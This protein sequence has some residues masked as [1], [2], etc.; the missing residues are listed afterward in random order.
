MVKAIDVARY[1]LY[2][3]ACEPE[4]EPL[5]PL[6]LQKLLY[7]AQGWS[8][9]L[10]ARPLF[11]E[12]IEAWDHGP[13]VREVYREFADHQ[14]Q[15]IGADGEADSVSLP[16][17]DK[18]FI[19]SIWDHYKQYSAGK[20]RAM[21]HEEAPWRSARGESRPGERCRNEIAHADLLRHFEDEFRRQSAQG[22][23]LERVRTAEREL[24]SVDSKP[25][26]YLADRI[27]HAFSGGH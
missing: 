16:Q 9:G 22:L 26:E 5:T 12:A 27:Q 24:E 19:R 8:M 13:V 21:T 17:G 1:L 6:R 18:D 15:P 23:S 4:P 14:D 3:A 25:L 2:L 20:L 10:R 7:Y 11:T